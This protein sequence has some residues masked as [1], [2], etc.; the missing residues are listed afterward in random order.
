MPSSAA[1]RRVLVAVDTA[2]VVT[3]SVLDMCHVVDAGNTASIAR[4]EAG[5]A[6]DSEDIH[7]DGR[8]RKVAVYR[9]LLDWVR[10]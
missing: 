10:V 5:C 2:Y 8:S 6:L 7:L 1:D 3:E 9:Q 4:E